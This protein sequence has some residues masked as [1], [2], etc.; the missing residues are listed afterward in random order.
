MRPW[1]VRVLTHLGALGGTFARLSLWGKFG[2]LYACGA[3]SP[4]IVPLPNSLAKP[5]VFRSKIEKEGLPR[6]STPVLGAADP[7]PATE[8]PREAS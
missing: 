5:F 8:I 6:G 3:T 4:Y 7:T 2:G 1:R